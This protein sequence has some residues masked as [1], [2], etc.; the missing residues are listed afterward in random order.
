MLLLTIITLFLQFQGLNAE[1]PDQNGLYL[2]DKV[3]AIERLM[4]TPGTIDFQVGPCNLD[5]NGPL[6]GSPEQSGD[7]V[8]LCSATFKIFCRD[9]QL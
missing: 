5:L 4:L 2:A 6:A 8:C 7:Q 9:S 1:I 3:L